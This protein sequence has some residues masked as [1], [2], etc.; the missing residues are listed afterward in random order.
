MQ[1]NKKE[2]KSAVS[3]G[4]R[5]KNRLHS[6]DEPCFAGRKLEQWTLVSV[7][8]NIEGSSLMNARLQLPAVEQNIPDADVRG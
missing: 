6:G 3:G 7:P 1:R 4:G 2:E 8:P 5:V